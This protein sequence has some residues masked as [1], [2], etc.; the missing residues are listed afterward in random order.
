MWL[1][2]VAGLCN[3]IGAGL[4]ARRAYLGTKHFFEM[5]ALGVISRASQ[6]SSNKSL[7]GIRLAQPPEYVEF[8]FVETILNLALTGFGFLCVGFLLSLANTFQSN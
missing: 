8:S 1:D 4:A 3:L 6:T 7:I 5:I 2:A